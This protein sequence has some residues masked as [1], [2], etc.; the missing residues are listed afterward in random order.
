MIQGVT[1]RVGLSAVSFFRASKKDAASIPHAETLDVS[2]FICV[3][4]V[5]SIF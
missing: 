4:F 1:A 3:Y 5:Y 2:N